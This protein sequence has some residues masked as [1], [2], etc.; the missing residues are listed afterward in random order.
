MTRRVLVT[1]GGSGIGRAI[2][3]DFAGA[4]DD[5]TI[6]G[7]RLDPLEETSAG[8]MTCVQADVTDEAQ[9]QAVFAAPFD[10]VVANAGT[11][12]AAKVRDTSLELWQSTLNT[13]LTGVFLTFRE[14]LR[15]GM[16]AGGR[17]I[18]IGSTQSLTAGAN[19]AAYAAAKHGVAGL[20]KALAHEVARSGQTC[21]AVCPGFVE[22]PMAEKGVQG[23][24]DRFDIPREEAVRRIVGN[25]PIGR[26]ITPQEVAAAVRYL[27]S[28]EAAMVN[29]HML[30]LSGGE[31]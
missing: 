6:T 29:G 27:A 28:D 19:I 31:V 13:T 22:T 3:R 4:G 10:V 15:S 26:M 20:V 7:R 9:M 2:A 16:G 30:A 1:G 14:A 5:V 8:Q 12:T 18:A 25:N 23:L 24:M 21:N 11:G 17:L